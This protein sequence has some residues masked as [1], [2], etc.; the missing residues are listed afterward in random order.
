MAAVSTVA[1]TLSTKLLSNAKSAILRVSAGIK[2]GAWIVRVS[3]STAVA[4]QYLPSA[5][6]ARAGL[7]GCT[8][9]LPQ[10]G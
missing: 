4:A 10:K 3:G 5:V 2:A 6:L 1:V 7:A 9:V 8:Q